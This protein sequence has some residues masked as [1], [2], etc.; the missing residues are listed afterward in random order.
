MTQPP[1]EELTKSQKDLVAIVS[2][3]VEQNKTPP[4][5]EGSEEIEEG[6][7]LL[8]WKICKERGPVAELRAEIARQQEQREKVMKKAIA[9]ATFV[10]AMV[11]GGIQIWGKMTSRAEANAEMVQAIK[12]LRAE[13]RTASAA[14]V[15]TKTP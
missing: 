2:G 13:V 1:K 7:R 6:L 5:S 8:R 11:T 12:E 9:L 4:P 3:V 10:V 14:Q 15:G